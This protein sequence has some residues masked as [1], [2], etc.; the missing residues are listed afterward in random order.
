MSKPKLKPCPFCGIAPTDIFSPH[1][2]CYWVRCG[3][4]D[5]WIKGPEGK[6]KKQAIILWNRRAK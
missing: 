4:T 6:T 2:T 5:C 1:N 3:G